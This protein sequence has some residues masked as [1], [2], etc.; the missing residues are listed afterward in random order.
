MT[1]QAGTT[2]EEAPVVLV[3]VIPANGGMFGG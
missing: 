2:T 1:P 3:S